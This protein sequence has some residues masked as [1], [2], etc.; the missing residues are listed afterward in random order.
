MFALKSAKYSHRHQPY[1]TELR[2]RTTE[3]TTPRSFRN[4]SLLAL[5]VYPNSNFI[6]PVRQVTEAVQNS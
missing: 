2:S 6:P 1:N 5:T 3:H 4:K